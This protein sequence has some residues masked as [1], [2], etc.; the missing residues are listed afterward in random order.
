MKM[1]PNFR[2]HAFFA[3]R[4]AQLQG[5]LNYII[6]GL[7]VSFAVFMSRRPFNTSLMV[8]GSP[9][10]TLKHDLEK[11]RALVSFK[12]LDVA[13]SLT[14]VITTH[15]DDRG[16][17]ALYSHLGVAKSSRLE[18]NALSTAEQQFIE[19]GGGL[20]KAQGW[21]D[22]PSWLGYGFDSKVVPLA[23]HEKLNQKIDQ[24]LFLSGQSDALIY[25]SSYLPLLAGSYISKL[26]SYNK[27]GKITCLFARRRTVQQEVFHA[28]DA[29]DI[30][31][32]SVTEF[33]SILLDVLLPTIEAACQS[34]DD[35]QVYAFNSTHWEK[36][37]EGVRHTEQMDSETDDRT[38]LYKEALAADPEAE[39]TATGSST[40][41]ENAWPRLIRDDKEAY[42]SIITASKSLK[43]V[44]SSVNPVD[45]VKGSDGREVEYIEGAIGL[46]RSISFFDATRERVLLVT[47]SSLQDMEAVSRAAREGGWSVREIE[48]VKDEWFNKCRFRPSRAHQNVRWG[49]MASKLRTLEMAD[50]IGGVLYMDL[51]I[52]VTGRLRRLFA[53]I[54]PEYRMVSEGGV[55]HE[56]LNA[57]FLFIRPD[58]D[59]FN[60]MIRYSQ[61]NP[62]PSIFNNIIDCTEMGLINSFFGLPDNLEEKGHRLLLQQRSFDDQAQG[63]TARLPLISQTLSV[64]RPDIKRTSP[65]RLPLA[66]H[67]IRKDLC[68][69]PWNVKCSMLE[70]DA[71]A[72]AG[73]DSDQCRFFTRFKNR[74]DLVAYIAWC[75]FRGKE[76]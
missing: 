67:F 2:A 19:A 6:V 75:Q 33:R 31:R 50:K 43:D 51:D 53:L 70:T 73:G 54:P 5:R 63:R 59:T 29:M 69:K 22:P 74:C 12:P 71:C 36:S 3:R 35:I 44:V 65:T 21:K 62:P 76:R 16:L 25:H 68:P 60:K 40:M 24:A 28:M 41:G 34:A 64:G 45:G 56:Y 37:E 47:R 20:V 7:L 49:L 13:P 55:Q 26:K 42:V 4:R 30:N 8:S 46:G 39:S 61:T 15:P 72:V 1:K 14:L 58:Q 23:E 17:E 32:V 11:E 38:I 52:V 27:G 18:D 10:A 66:F 9:L 57:G 48:P